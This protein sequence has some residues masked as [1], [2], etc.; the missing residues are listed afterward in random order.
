M[1]QSTLEPYRV[2]SQ[3]LYYSMECAA[4]TQEWAFGMLCHFASFRLCQPTQCTKCTQPDLRHEVA[5]PQ[6][7]VLSSSS[8]WQISLLLKAAPSKGHGQGTRAT[9]S[10]AVAQWRTRWRL[11]SHTRRRTRWRREAPAR[12][13]V[14]SPHHVTA[15][16]WRKPHA[17]VGQ[18]V[19]SCGEFL[20][21]GCPQCACREA[22]RVAARG[23]GG[24]EHFS[25]A[26]A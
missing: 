12:H 23:Q 24:E 22:D 18:S 20:A 25:V 15:C 2:S 21:W 8:A 10:T 3:F 26:S 1:I 4:V 13:P 6:G 9:A 14:A 16:R 5:L 19:G 11:P 17:E 7:L